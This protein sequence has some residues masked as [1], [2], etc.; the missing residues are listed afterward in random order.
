MTSFGRR[1]AELVKEVAVTD[2]SALPAYNVR[3]RVRCCCARNAAG[4]RKKTAAAGGVQNQNG[5]CVRA[6]ARACAGVQE[7]LLRVVKEETSE[8]YRALLSS[9]GRI[10]ATADASEEGGGGAGA[11]ASAAPEDAAAVMVHNRALLR[12][13]RLM[14]AY[15]CVCPLPCVSSA[16]TAHIH[17]RTRTRFRCVCGPL[18]D[19]DRSRALLFCVASATRAWGGSRR[20]AGR[21][22]AACRRTW[23][24][25]CRRLKKTFS[26]H[27][28][29]ALRLRVRSVFAAQ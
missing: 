17:T 22:A 27:T 15:V 14:L 1:A 2:D 9:L 4:K 6:D 28:T 25:R 23:R 3:V 7:Q 18:A 29:S 10:Q 8:H 26:E 21:W 12:N 13:K 19:P 20:C 5:R 11:E 16:C 24:R